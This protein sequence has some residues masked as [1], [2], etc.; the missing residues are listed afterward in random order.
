M[1]FHTSETTANT[2]ELFRGHNYKSHVFQLNYWHKSYYNKV[3]MDRLESTQ[4]R[5]KQA[6]MNAGS[7][8]KGQTKNSCDTVRYSGIL[9]IGRALKGHHHTLAS[10]CHH[11]PLMC[12]FLVTI[13]SF[14]QE[15]FNTHI[16]HQ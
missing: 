6:N 7:C 2:F 12:T 10:S 3:G 11:E 15:L 5:R 1:C 14:E 16:S 13:L 4:E 8:D 9:R